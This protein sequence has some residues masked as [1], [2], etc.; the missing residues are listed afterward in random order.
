MKILTAAQIREADAFTIE[1][2]NLGPAE[3]ME[4]AAMAFA[5]WFD[6]NCNREKEVAVFCGPGNNGGDGLAIARLLFDNDFLVRV[7]L[8]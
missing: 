7:F 5:N 8:P 6:A 3:L 2:E 1:R 4:R